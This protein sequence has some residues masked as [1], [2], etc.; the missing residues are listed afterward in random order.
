MGREIDTK[1]VKE[2]KEMGNIDLCGEKGEFHT[3]VY[4]GPISKNP[5]KFIT[6][7]K[8]LKD[9]HCFLELLPQK[10]EVIRNF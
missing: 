3:F 8:V 7:D 4:E 2:F 1:L 10:K 9:T 5:V 6:G